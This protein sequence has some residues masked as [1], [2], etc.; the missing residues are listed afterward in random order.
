VANGLD[1]PPWIEFTPWRAISGHL[2]LLKYGN[3][4]LG[5]KCAHH[6]SLKENVMN[7]TQSAKR[8]Q[9]QGA[10]NRVTAEVI[11]C[12]GQLWDDAYSALQ[13]NVE[14]FQSPYVLTLALRAVGYKALSQQ[15][16][17]RSVYEAIASAVNNAN[18]AVEV[19]ANA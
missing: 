10:L 14:G 19:K 5:R 6:R 8:G 7:G 17:P 13:I 3:P 2:S 16:D 9:S 4:I 11:S 12:P 1:R 15:S 18:I